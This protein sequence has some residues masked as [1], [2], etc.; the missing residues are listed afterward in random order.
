MTTQ[1][2][3]LA[4]AGAAAVMAVVAAVR[5]RGRAKRRD[6]DQVGWVPWD[7]LQIIFGL[8]AVVATVLAFKLG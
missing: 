4:A 3:F 2:M 6:L 7:V 1:A 5:D 8:I